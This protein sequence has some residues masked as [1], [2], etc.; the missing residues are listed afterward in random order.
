MSG[1]RGESTVPIETLLRER[2]EEN[3]APSCGSSDP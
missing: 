1:E 3:R 2:R